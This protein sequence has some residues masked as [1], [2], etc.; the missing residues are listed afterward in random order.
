MSGSKDV[1]K[2]QFKRCETV[3]ITKNMYKNAD[4]N[5]TKMKIT[6]THDNP[7]RNDLENDIP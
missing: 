6:L 2:A 5:Y 1:R 3:A 7:H 4:S